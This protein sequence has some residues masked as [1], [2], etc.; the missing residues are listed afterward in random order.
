M[1]ERPPSGSITLFRVAGIPIQFHF[2][3]LFLAALLV[4]SGLL[5]RREAILDAVLVAAVFASVLLHELGHALAALRFGVKIVSITMYPIGGAARLASQPTPQQEIW[6]TVMG[7]AVNL[8]LAGACWL[9]A[10]A[11]TG[12]AAELLTQLGG[13]NVTLLLFNLI[14]AFPMDGGRLLRAFVALRQPERNATR[15]ATTI[16]RLVALAMGAFALFNG[17]WFL[18]FIAIFVF[19]G[20]Q[21]ERMVSETRHLSTGSPVSAAMIR[22]FRTLPHGATVREA[23]QLLLDTNQ[24]DFPVVHGQQ[25]IGLLRRPALIAAMGHPGPESYVAGV[26]D[27][28]FVTLPPTMDLTDALGLMPQAG[29]CALVVEDDKLV[30]LLTPENIGEFFALRAV[31]ARP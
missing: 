27:R 29:S 13:A 16:G 24:Q 8:V 18:L 15:L 6:I 22:D 21:Q 10:R 19:L 2:T 12:D 26:M 25:L 5:G 28:D 14:P 9:G 4:T 17:Q 11:T 20:A 7:P 30:G 31:E 1:A 3:F 23:A